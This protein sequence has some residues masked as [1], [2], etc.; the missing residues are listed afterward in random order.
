MSPR[1]KTGDPMRA[2]N[3]SSRWSAVPALILVIA[4]PAIAHAEEGGASITPGEISMDQVAELRIPMEGGRSLTPSVPGLTFQPSGQSSEMTNVNGSV[5]QHTWQLYR[6]IADRPGSYAIPVGADRLSLNVVPAGGRVG[7]QASPRQSMDSASDDAG[8]IAFLR[9]HVSKKTLYVGEAFP[10]AFRAYFRPGTEITLAAPPTLSNPAFTVSD[11]SEKPVQTTQMV[12]GRE[13]VVATWTAL[14]S[15][16]L[17]GTFPTEVTLPIVAR[18][19]EARPA[20]DPTEDD[21]FSGDPMASAMLRSMFGPGFGGVFAGFGDPFGAVRQRELTLHSQPDSLTLVPLPLAGRP[22]GFS[23][24]IGQFNVKA[25]L[26]PAAGT[27][28]EPMSFQVSVSGQGNFDRVS[29]AGL[30]SSGELKAY[31]THSTFE[32]K[33]SRSTFTGTRTFI[34]PIVPQKAGTL[35]IPSVAFTFFDP[36]TATYVTQTTAP[37][38][39]QVAPAAAAGPSLSQSPAVS[40]PLSADWRP[41]HDATAS[42]ASLQLPDRQPTFWV[43]LLLPVLGL[44]ALL[45]TTRHSSR[46]PSERAKVREA[47][48]ERASRRLAM[49]KAAESRDAA[50]FFDAARMV[51]QAELGKLWSLSPEQVTQSEVERRLGEQGKT[52]ADALHTAEAMRYGAARVDSISLIECET[53]LEQALHQLEVAP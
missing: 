50:R 47:R 11:L 43:A 44:G 29:L 52:L 1:R 21:P 7:S 4:L 45:Q 8:P 35:E 10:M 39:S 26:T 18:Y 30:N 5:S 17:A 53:T 28:F 41:N 24:A 16:N 48:A 46:G 3:F 36:K 2:S 22:L 51:V 25:A 38:H 19:R 20:V 6:V 27:A 42:A 32:P 23:G 34:Q 12:E 9:T 15:G 37:I 33:T 13:Y 14:V 31:P 40:P 49:R